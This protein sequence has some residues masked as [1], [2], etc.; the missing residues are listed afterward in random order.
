MA[1][2]CSSPWD[3]ITRFLAATDSLYTNR[4]KCIGALSA[5][6]MA[7]ANGMPDAQIK[8]RAKTYLQGH[9]C[10]AFQP[11]KHLWEMCILLLILSKWM[12][13]SLPPSHHRIRFPCLSLCG[14]EQRMQAIHLSGFEL[15][16]NRHRGCLLTAMRFSAA[17]LSKTMGGSYNPDGFGAP[18]PERL[19]ADSGC[20]ENN[21]PLEGPL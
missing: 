6:W 11:K 18:N 17:P 16:V 13:F 4:G 12:G 9:P 5:K 8:T 19:S 10:Q 7:L 1:S 15:P 21:F 2:I 14:R 3:K 20:L